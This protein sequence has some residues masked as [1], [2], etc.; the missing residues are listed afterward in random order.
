MSSKGGE[1]WM[2]KKGCARREDEQVK[3]GEEG[4]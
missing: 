4:E 2:G 1:E 3:L